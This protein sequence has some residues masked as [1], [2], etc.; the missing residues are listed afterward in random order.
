MLKGPDRV[1]PAAR[2]AA[3]VVPLD[4]ARA[5]HHA[6]S[7]RVL[8]HA[9]YFLVGVA[10]GAAELRSGLLEFVIVLAVTLSTSWATTAALRKTPFV[11][12]MIS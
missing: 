7:S 12:R 4:R 8:L 1:G 3:R 10:V 6:L 5:L 11:A 2:V 9:G